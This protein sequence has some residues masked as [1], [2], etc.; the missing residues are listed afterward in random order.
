METPLCLDTI[1]THLCTSGSAPVCVCV[2]GGEG[3]GGG[4]G[5]GIRKVVYEYS[6]NA[7]AFHLYMC[8]KHLNFI[9]K[10]FPFSLE[11]RVEGKPCL[12]CHRNV[13]TIGTNNRILQE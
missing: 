1:A 13:D 6:E 2:C 8:N 10:E 4:G 7:G 3:G 5:E 12:P 9:S 11:A